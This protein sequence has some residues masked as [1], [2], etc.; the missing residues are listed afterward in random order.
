[1]KMS[2]INIETCKSIMG[3]ILALMTYI[4]VGVLVEDYLE[5]LGIKRLKA[6]ILAICWPPTIVLL[7]LYHLFDILGS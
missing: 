1:M 4:S 7:F 5:K 2:E 3:I 6:L